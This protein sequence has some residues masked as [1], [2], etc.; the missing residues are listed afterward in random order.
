MIANI[1]FEFIGHL[2][3]KINEAALGSI[4]LLKNRACFNALVRA[5]FGGGLW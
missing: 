3:V 5:K 1:R 2:A 4:K